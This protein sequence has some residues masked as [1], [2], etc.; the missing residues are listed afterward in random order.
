MQLTDNAKQVVSNVYNQTTGYLNRVLNTDGNKQRREHV[1]NPACSTLRQDAEQV[2]ICVYDYNATSIQQ[3]EFK[4]VKETFPFKDNGN[5]SW[6][7][8][9]GIR[10]ADVEAIGEH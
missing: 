5:I 7:N 1:Y 9:D 3:H 10:K 2:K 4:D 8:I 6:I